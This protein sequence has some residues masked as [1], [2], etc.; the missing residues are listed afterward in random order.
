MKNLKQISLE[1]VQIYKQN[2]KVESILLAGSVSRDW[3]DDHSDIELHIFWNEP[4]NDE[5]RLSPIRKVN[6]SL[7]SFHPYEDEE[8]SESY[9]TNEG[10][11]LEISSFLTGSVEQFISDVVNKYETDYDKQ[12]IAASI[13]YG[14]V[15]F[16]EVKIKELKNNVRKYPDEL[17]KAMILENLQ[18]GNRW[19]N[20]QA[21]LDRQDWLMLY[22]VICEVQKKLLGVLFGLNNM[23]VHHPSFKWMKNSI[24]IM[25]VKP[26]NL[27]ERMTN[28]LSGN[29][30]NSVKELADLIQET[31]D[32][33][34]KHYPQLI[35]NE[36]KRRLAYL[37]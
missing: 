9:M 33:A 27:Y 2:P 8:W 26:H 36:H 24:D 29:P 25:E 16:G 11:K 5:D 1:M 15:L 22:S 7:L 28:I 35:S 31:V 13:H 3:Q 32:L 21:L 30:V 12:C 20:R 34:E 6:G 4:P 14:E 17:S 37:K 18:L 10:V 19:D 23:Y